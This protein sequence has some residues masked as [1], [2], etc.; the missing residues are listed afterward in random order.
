VGGQGLEQAIVRERG[1]MGW[2]HVLVT[3]LGGFIELVAI[4]YAAAALGVV[5]AETADANA[6][7]HAGSGAIPF[8]VGIYLIGL[9]LA[10]YGYGRFDS[11]E[12]IR[13]LPVVLVASVAIVLIA[14]IGAA[15][16]ALGGGGGGDGGGDTRS[17]RRSPAKPGSN[18]ACAVL[19]LAL[20]A[21]ALGGAPS[22]PRPG[23][24]R[25]LRL[26][27]ASCTGPDGKARLFLGV[28]TISRRLDRRIRRMEAR[29]G[30][31]YYGAATEHER[32]WT[33]YDGGWEIS[34]RLSGREFSPQERA[35]VGELVKAAME[36][37]RD[38]EGRIASPA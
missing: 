17:S 22:A 20:A 24:S 2:R 5:K 26:S 8:I 31:R 30:K 25:A 38:A 21:R 10:A 28:R 35:A 23:K 32:G 12:A 34:A 3:A 11:R 29:D 1:R 37:I 9:A 4:A 19:D 33:L 27:S 15:V 36:R 16:G 6:F 13:K 18:M 14:A 7:A